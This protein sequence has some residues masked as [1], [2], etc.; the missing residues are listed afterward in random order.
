MIKEYNVVIDDNNLPILNV[1]KEINVSNLDLSVSDLIEILIK[2]YFFNKLINEETMLGCFD[3]QSNLI[4][5]FKISI[6]TSE[7]SYLYKNTIATALLLTGTRQFVVVH[8]HTYNNP[9]FPSEGDI[10]NYNSLIELSKL[11]SISF[12]DS[13]IINKNGWYSI[14][15]G[16]EYEF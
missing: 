3:N 7:K 9:L 15:E 4:G 12:V 6:G 10:N 8:N 14:L 11:L 16:K 5:L 1:L 13:I 2:Y